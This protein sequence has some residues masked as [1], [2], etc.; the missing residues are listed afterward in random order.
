M[1]RVTDRYFCVSYA[2]LVT[3][4]QTFLKIFM[5]CLRS[6]PYDIAFSRSSE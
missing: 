4:N 6:R 3:V 1:S 2:A 5:L